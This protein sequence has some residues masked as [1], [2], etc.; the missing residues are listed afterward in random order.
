MKAPKNLFIAFLKL[1]SSI[2][3]NLSSCRKTRI[4]IGR[5]I[6]RV[7]VNDE[8]ESH[9]YE[10]LPPALP[11]RQSIMNISPRISASTFQND[12]QG[13]NIFKLQCT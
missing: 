5:S 10:V 7:K 13:Q 8:A 12:K 11:S 6:I 4:S 3:T 2:R 1:D 9:D